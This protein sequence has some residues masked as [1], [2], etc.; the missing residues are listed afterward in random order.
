MTSSGPPR[1]CPTALCAPGATGVTDVIDGAIF[2][3]FAGECALKVV[4]E[5]ARPLRYLHGARRRRLK[6]SIGDRRRGLPRRGG[7]RSDGSIVMVL[8][9]LRAAVLKLVRAA[10]VAGIVRAPLGHRL[11]RVRLDAAAAHLHCDR[12][13]HPLRGQRPALPRRRQRDADAL[14]AST[15]EDWTDVMYI[16]CTLD[17]HPPNQHAGAP[18]RQR[19]SAT[20][21]RQPVSRWLSSSRPS[22][23]ARDDTLFIGVAD[24]VDGPGEPEAGEGPRRGRR[25]R[26]DRR[27]APPRRP[28]P[29]RAARHLRR[30]AAAAETIDSKDLG[31]VLDGVSQGRMAQLER[32]ERIDRARRPR[33]GAPSAGCAARATHARAHHA[34]P[35]AA[36]PP[37]A[38]AARA[39]ARRRRTR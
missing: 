35:R 32:E 22:R 15:L 6:P 19:R 29:R 12:R 5:G 13:L 36:R 31:F 11:H 14:R 37:P 25:D 33:Q 39:A 26:R 10:A 34:R 24:D 30:G 27:R 20:C 3:I 9:L 21:P 7:V 28:P 8:R 17:R 18:L 23:G 1:C 38:A 4:A 2:L 16:N